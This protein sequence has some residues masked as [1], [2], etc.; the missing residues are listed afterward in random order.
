LGV[1]KALG[2]LKREVYEG[3]GKF[4]PGRE[5]IQQGWIAVI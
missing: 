1:K 2:D 5:F 3:G 4:K